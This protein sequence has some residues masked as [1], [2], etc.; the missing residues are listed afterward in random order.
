MRKGLSR[1]SDRRILIR[2]FLP[3]RRSPTQRGQDGDRDRTGIGCLRFPRA[4]PG[5]PAGAKAILAAEQDWV[6]GVPMDTAPSVCVDGLTVEDILAADWTTSGHFVAER[7][8]QRTAP[9]PVSSAPLPSGPT[10]D[11]RSVTQPATEE[12][13]E[14]A[15]GDATLART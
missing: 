12:E 7:D 11:G 9:T 6:A 8:R 10:C 3:L 13:G 15:G 2:R 5:V 4:F 14:S 1:R